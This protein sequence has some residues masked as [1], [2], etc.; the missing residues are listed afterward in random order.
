MLTNLTPVVLTMNDLY[1]I[2][3]TLSAIVGWFDRV[4]IYDVGS[5]DGTLDV[6]RWF[7]DN[8]K[9]EILLEEFPFVEPKAQ[10]AF[11][12]ALIAD[13]QS[14]YYIQV[15]GDEVWS[16]DSLKALSNEFEAFVKS[17]KLYGQVRRIEVV[18]DGNFGHAYGTNK[19]VP[20]TRLYHRTCTWRGNHPGER[21]T[22]PIKGSDYNFS[23]DA[24]CYHFHNS[25][26]SPLDCEVPGR[27]KRRSQ[28]TYHPGKLEEIDLFQALPILKNPVAGFK[29]NPTLELLQNRTKLN[30][31]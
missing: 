5:K 15:D 24:I 31:R 27:V 11:R 20:H 26:R 10:L 21:P 2:P 3:Y 6:L 28:K 17:G 19:F 29:A 16:E 4:V 13:A 9:C 12:N 30:W 1:W 18:E 23:W 7:K 8:S 14:E 25:S 22:I